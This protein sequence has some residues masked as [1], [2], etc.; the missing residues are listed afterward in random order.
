MARL[1]ARLDESGLAA[2]I[3]FGPDGSIDSADPAE[4]VRC[5]D[6]RP[7]AP[8]RDERPSGPIVRGKAVD[9]LFGPAHR[10]MARRTSYAQVDLELRVGH[11]SAGR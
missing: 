11:A 7:T 1:P 8:P 9:F 6:P 4:S 5:K 2:R 10:A 3:S